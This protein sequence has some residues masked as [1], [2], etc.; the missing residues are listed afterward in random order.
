MTFDLGGQE[1][2]KVIGTHSAAVVQRWPRQKDGMKVHPNY[3]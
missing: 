1:K 2:P 3:N